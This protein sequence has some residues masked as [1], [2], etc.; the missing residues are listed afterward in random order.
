MIQFH[1]FRHKNAIC[2]RCIQLLCTE[3]LNSYDG[4]ISG[5]IKKPAVDAAFFNIKSGV[6]KRKHVSSNFLHENIANRGS[7]NMVTLLFIVINKTFR[8][9]MNVLFPV[10]ILNKVKHIILLKYVIL[11]YIVFL[12]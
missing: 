12:L 4:I 2:A 11:L 8:Y 9:H 6:E 3:F 7:H 10:N 1:G 5:N